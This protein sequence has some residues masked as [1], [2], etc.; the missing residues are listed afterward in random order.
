MIILP[1]SPPLSG[2][3]S[4]LFCLRRTDRVSSS[5]VM[6]VKVSF[7]DDKLGDDSGG[8]GVA[9][10]SDMLA[11]K[12]LLVVPLL[13]GTSWDP[14]A[15]VVIISSLEKLPVLKD[16]SSVLHSISRSAVDDG[17]G[18]DSAMTCCPSNAD[19]KRCS[20]FTRHTLNLYVHYVYSNSSS[21]HLTSVE[22]INRETEAFL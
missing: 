20:S 2:L 12:V 21:E 15:V 22:K 13:L 17:C 7:S 4:F 11:G 5:V 10:S 8:V 9:S 1:G 6:M 18:L 19:K 14:S 16:C 3:P